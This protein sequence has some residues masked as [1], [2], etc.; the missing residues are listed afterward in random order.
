[1]KLFRDKERREWT[2]DVTVATLRRIRDL[3][4]LDLANPHQGDPPPIVRMDSDVSLLVDVL[5]AACKPQA[6]AAGVDGEHFAAVLGGRALADARSALMQD[7]TLFF[8]ESG[9][10]DVARLMEAHERLMGREVAANV[11]SLDL[12]KI[13]AAFEAVM[14]K[15]A[16]QIAGEIERLDLRIL[17]PSSPSVPASSE[18]TPAP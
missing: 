12:E 7:L 15:K 6:D 9:R 11:A 2:V 5:F 4:G 17:G 18:S 3:A 16:K 1:M 8:Q 13:D 14:A 10:D